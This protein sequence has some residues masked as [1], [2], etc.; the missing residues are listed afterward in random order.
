MQRISTSS[1]MEGVRGLMLWYLQS[2]TS[3][4]LLFLGILKYMRIYMDRNI[5][6]CEEGF[7]LRNFCLCWQQDEIFPG[8]RRQKGERERERDRGTRTPACEHYLSHLTTCPTHH[9]EPS[10]KQ[11]TVPKP[12]DLFTILVSRLSQHI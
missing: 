7:R 9:T 8:V 12:E 11:S 2:R 1:M 4:V 5:K 10:R 6:V 3:L